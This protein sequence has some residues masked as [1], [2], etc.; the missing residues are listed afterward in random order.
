V[1]SVD[2]LRRILAVLFGSRHDDDIDDDRRPAEASMAHGSRDD[3]VPMNASG[4][5]DD[6]DEAEGNDDDAGGD[7]G[8]GD[9]G[10]SD[11]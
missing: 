10:G 1:E 8:G 7:D 5:P 11:D 3:A 2:W 9:D 6:R 4:S